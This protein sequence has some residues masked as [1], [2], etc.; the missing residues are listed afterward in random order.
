MRAIALLCCEGAMRAIASSMSPHVSTRQG[1]TPILCAATAGVELFEPTSA[2]PRRHFQR[3]Q[4]VKG[5]SP[6]EPRVC[7][8]IKQY[9]FCSAA[10][11]ASYPS[12]ATPASR[13]TSSML[14]HVSLLRPRRKSTNETCIDN[15]AKLR[16]QASVLALRPST[17]NKQRAAP[18]VV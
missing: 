10:Q 7:I 8:Q 3:S 15:T 13:L 12:P 9:L 11:L 16:P 5:K 14:P 6:Q 2:P 1:P 17:C 4:L 18:R